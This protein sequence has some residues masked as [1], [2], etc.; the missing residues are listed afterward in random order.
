MT[1]VGEMKTVRIK[2]PGGMVKTAIYVGPNSAT[3]KTGLFKFGPMQPIHTFNLRTGAGVGPLKGW[4][5]EAEDLEK[6]RSEK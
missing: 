6:L 2:H 4:R 1:V 5:I 3:G